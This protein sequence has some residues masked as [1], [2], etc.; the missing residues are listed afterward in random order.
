MNKDTIVLTGGGTAGHVTPHINLQKELKKHFDKIIYIG[1][2]TGIEKN[3]IKSK[4]NYEYKEID[5]VKFIRRKLFKNLLIPFK[6]SKA[7]KEAKQILKETKPSIIFSKGGYVSLPVAIAGKKLGIPVVSHES[8]LSM[9]LANKI[10]KKYSTKICTNFELTAKKNGNKCVHTGT[11]L[12]I[13][14][15]SKEKAKEKLNVPNTKPTVLIA[16]GSLGAKAI[17]K[18]ITD[19]LN[20]L[21]KKYYIIHLVGN[22]NINEDIKNENY[23]QIEFF[24]DMPT[25]YKATDFAISRAG[26]NTVF[27]LLANGIPSIFIP[28][29]KNASRGDQIDNANYTEALGLSKTILQENLN[30]N[31]L[32]SKLDYIE[33]NAK[34]LKTNIKNHQFSDG[35]SK[36]MKIILK[37]KIKHTA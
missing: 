5:T 17:N 29:P 35:S 14:D 9:G 19:N 2:K 26:A 13:S 18:F 6:L 11:P 21:T 37:E 34:K 10:S 23:R 1:S 22:G 15:I 16:G 8:D 4:T 28:L 3:L 32:L 31:S 33:K 7:I 12:I 27:E 30:I 24:N 25:L 36:I 20:Q